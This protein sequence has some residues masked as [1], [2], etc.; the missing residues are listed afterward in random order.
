[1]VSLDEKGPLPFLA[2]AGCFEDRAGRLVLSED[3]LRRL[4]AVMQSRLAALS[5][6]LLLTCQSDSA[7][8]WFYGCRLDTSEL[9]EG[10]SRGR[11]HEGRSRERHREGRSRER[12]RVNSREPVL[13]NFVGLTRRPGPWRS[14]LFVRATSLDRKC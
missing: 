3:R 13:T 10:R 9:R 8:S 7:S 6:N 11:H 5:K 1:M 14:H 12:R 4:A 2:Y